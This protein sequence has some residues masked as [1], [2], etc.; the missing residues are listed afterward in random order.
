MT[1]GNP[2]FLV[3]TLRLLV[4]EGAISAAG[5]ESESRWQWNGI[6][7]VPLP[8]S[9]VMAALGKLERLPAELRGLL[10]HAAVI[11]DEFRLEPLARMSSRGE[12]LL[13]ES[14]REGIQLGVL[15]ERGVSIGE[16]YRFY[17]TTTE[18][19]LQ[20]IP[21]AAV[22]PAPVP[23]PPSG[24][25]ARHPSACKALSTHYEAGA[26]RA[27]SAVMRAWSGRARDGTG[28]RP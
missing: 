12:D 3:E 15:A 16:D 23:P 28:K 21:H 2:Y 9:L 19:A 27:P 5:D 13:D 26:R 6:E 11:G 4:A 10:E 7:N 8:D 18:G 14:L 20:S 25:P 17:H 1:G 22:P 24:S